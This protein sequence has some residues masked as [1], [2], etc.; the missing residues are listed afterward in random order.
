M[1]LSDGE[2]PIRWSGR[3]HV[4]ADWNDAWID[5]VS[6]ETVRARNGMLALP[7]CFA[8]FPV[9]LL[10]HGGAFPTPLVELSSYNSVGSRAGTSLAKYDQVG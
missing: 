6:G 10:Y 5:I 4:P 8:S 1:Q 7:D 9:A 3:V 2:Q